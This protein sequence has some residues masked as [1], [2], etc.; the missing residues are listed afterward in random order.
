MQQ[1]E[2]FGTRIEGATA[3]ER[4]W[5]ATMCDALPTEA[6]VRTPSEWAEQRR[7]LPQSVTPRAGFFRWDVCP[8]LREILDCFDPD[9]PVREVAVMK[10][11][12]ICATTAIL[13]NVLGYF[14]EDVKTAPTMWVTGDADMMQTRLEVN[15]LPMFQHSGLDDL[16]RSSDAQN[17]RKTGRTTK[18]VEWF[19]G[20]YLLPL[21]AQNPNKFRQ[22]PALLL[23]LDEIDAWPLNAKN[24]GDPVGLVC[25]RAA[26]YEAVKKVG[27]LST[28]TI[29]GQSQIE[30]LYLLGD[31]R[32]YFVRC[33]KC[34]A[35]Q[36][37]KWS[38]VSD[39]GVK[40][41]IVWDTEKDLLVPGSVRYLCSECGHAHANNDK[42]RLLSPNEGAEWR[43]TAEPR[44]PHF[45]SYHVPALLSPTGMQT[46]EA[47]VG[48]YLEVFDVKRNRPHDNGKYQVWYNQVLGSTFELRG[49]RARFVEVSAHRRSE[50]RYGQ[51]PNRWAE[52]HCGSPVLL[53]TAAVDVH[54][55]NLAV[56]VFGWTR[57]RRGILLDY[58][59]L[60]GEAEQLSDAPT[61]GALRKIIENREYEADDGKRYRI[62]LTFIDSGYSADLVYQFASE[63]RRG[64]IPIKG[65]ATPSANQTIREF[66]DFT[67]PLGQR[68]L[69]ISVDLYKDRWIASLRQKW[70]GSGLQR[71]NSF[72][73]PVDCTDA[74]LK[75]LTVE[76]KQER[77]DKRTNRRLGWEWHRTS[78][79]RNE[80]WDLLVY[81]AAAVD[82]IAWDL[83]RNQ[84]GLEAVNW[85]AF[86]DRL[87][88]GKVFFR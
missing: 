36:H 34:N 78:G 9:S 74:Q 30:S 44:R 56:A 62:E 32:K 28:P 71:Q 79:V 64:V 29:R 45:R 42:E 72:N 7:Y 52:Q 4:E 22:Q 86:W 40:S 54:K 70:D 27:Y 15:I 65:Q 18:K 13:E 81:N 35:P 16:I 80:L 2:A 57:G 53:V 41:G 17:R 76:R 60:T 50:Y 33:L 37:M 23:L 63:Y 21:G 3:G 69:N 11:V 68:A 5:L 61:W 66:S 87:E 51:I 26:A 47:L 59:R 77:I 19:G 48:Q 24:E 10:G 55:D 67:T 38:R 49:D 12:Q 39:D 43:P 83:C 85:T 20:G 14:I 73:A 8:Y 58:W 1:L 25:K 82:V 31:Q 75:E 88:A 6:T 84:L 46:W